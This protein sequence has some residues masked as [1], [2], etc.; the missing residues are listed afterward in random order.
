MFGPHPLIRIMST[1]RGT[2]TLTITKQVSTTTT[3]VTVNPFGESLGST[4]THYFCL[5]LAAGLYCGFF[6]VLD[7]TQLYFDL[8]GAFICAKRH[9]SKKPY[10]IEFERNL[11][12]N[13]LE[14]TDELLER[15][16]K[17]QPSMCFILSMQENPL[18]F[19]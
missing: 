19:S 17:P 9:K 16:Y 11:K 4:T 2:S 18:I 13:L 1:T 7:R 5:N 14:L 12:K 15:R 10:V 3:A 8:Y 6:M